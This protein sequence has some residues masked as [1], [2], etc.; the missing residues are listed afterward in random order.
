MLQ[1]LRRAMGV[2]VTAFMMLL[3][4]CGSLEV[5]HHKPPGN[6]LTVSVAEEGLSFWTEVD[7]G[8]AP[9]LR[10]SMRVAGR[11]RTGFFKPDGF[12]E[13]GLDSHVVAVRRMAPAAMPLAPRAVVALQR[14]ASWM[15]P[16]RLQVSQTEEPAKD[17]DVQVVPGVLLQLLGQGVVRF[18]SQL[19]TRY[20]DAKGERQVRTYR[21]V[22]R[23]DMPW[24]GSG[25]TW[26][27][28]DHLL[29]KRQIDTSFR[30]LGKVMLRDVRG[31]FKAEAA[32]PSPNLLG[33]ESA[34]LITIETYE[35]A[36][37]DQLRVAY[38]VIG[39]NRSMKDLFVLDDAPPASV[40]GE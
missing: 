21:Y 3:A 16:L 22:G 2:L 9:I 31:D 7:S 17:A 18:E 15:A 27:M 19:L 28:D 10:Q 36:R 38:Q 1:V 34:G 26:T 37:F 29:L 30:A 23:Y 35:L 33:K 24:V 40:F 25:N 20:L 39:R 8:S 11:D 4:G 32:S 12:V 5:A 14:E 6:T 13:S